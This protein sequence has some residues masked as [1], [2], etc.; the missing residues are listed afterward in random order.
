MGGNFRKCWVQTNLIK[1]RKSCG[2]SEILGAQT[3]IWLQRVR[4]PCLRNFGSK[5]YYPTHCMSV[6]FSEMWN[7]KLCLSL[8]E[9]NKVHVH[10]CSVHL[11]NWPFFISCN[12]LGN[13]SQCKNL[14]V[15]FFVQ[16]FLS[17]FLSLFFKKKPFF[18]FNLY[19][20]L[21]LFLI[22][23]ILEFQAHKRCQ[24]NSPESNFPGWTWRW[25]ITS[26]T[27]PGLWG[28]L[29]QHREESSEELHQPFLQKCF[30][31]WAQLA[32]TS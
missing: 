28:Q 29:S 22:F 25:K 16:F 31:W 23:I 9:T 32:A 30:V 6:M 5:I 12:Y 7:V 2:C 24:S 17:L 8:W 20:C 26:L 4:R 21:F 13:K 11:G 27:K 14:N 15:A 3:G 19:F 18:S 10:F 1:I